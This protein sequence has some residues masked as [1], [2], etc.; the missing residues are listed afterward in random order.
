MNECYSGPTKGSAVQTRRKPPASPGQPSSSG[1][2]H[3]NTAKNRGTF[4][5]VKARLGAFP[6]CT[7]R[8]L[9]ASPRAFRKH[10]QS[11]WDPSV[12]PLLGLR[13]GFVDLYSMREQRRCRGCDVN[14]KA[15]RTIRY[16]TLR[17]ADVRPA[18]V[19][20]ERG[21]SEVYLIATGS[22]SDTYSVTNLLTL[23][24]AQ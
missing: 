13:T 16:L 8:N 4:A 20:L 21:R 19:N 10:G 12:S 2:P 3:Q 23:P 7:L 6:T 22:F 1:L 9:G 24:T 15:L 18:T 17:N 11:S 5:F 14:F